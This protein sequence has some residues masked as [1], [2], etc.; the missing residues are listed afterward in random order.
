MLADTL[1]NKR[2]IDALKA[3]EKSGLEPEY[4]KKVETKEEEDFRVNANQSLT[5]VNMTI[6][7]SNGQYEKIFKGDVNNGMA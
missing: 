6:P 7:Y 2:Y 5:K 4:T 1:E 3:I